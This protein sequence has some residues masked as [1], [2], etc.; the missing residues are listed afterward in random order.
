MSITEF[1]KTLVRQLSTLPVAQ[2]EPSA[3][4]RT[5]HTF[6]K[7]SGPGRKKKGKFAR[8]A[9]QIYEK[10][11]PAVKIT[12]KLVKPQATATTVQTNPDYVWNVLI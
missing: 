12:T 1:R 11:L 10:P 7:P 2:N 6:I 3:P 8:D 5:A 9:T 4:K